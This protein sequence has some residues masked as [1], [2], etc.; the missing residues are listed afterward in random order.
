MPA[1]PLVSDVFSMTGLQAHAESLAYCYRPCISVTDVLSPRLFHKPKSRRWLRKRLATGFERSRGGPAKEIEASV[2]GEKKFQ[3]RPGRPERS[4]SG[5]D[6]GFLMDV[7]P[8]K[9]LSILDLSIVVVRF[10]SVR[11]VGA[12]V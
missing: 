2:A 6:R 9:F 12:G 1:S 5:L 8:K 7:G 10:V 3:R 11:G 4:R